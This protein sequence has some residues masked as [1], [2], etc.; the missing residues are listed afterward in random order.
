M[1]ILTLVFA[2]L[3]IF[4]PIVL[5]LRFSR[6]STDQIALVVYCYIFGATANIIAA[7]SVLNFTAELLILIS[8]VCFFLSCF[9]ISSQN[10]LAVIGK[11]FLYGGPALTFAVSFVEKKMEYVEVIRILSYISLFFVFVF[12]PSN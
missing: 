6:N 1:E 10:K 3:S 7:S 4:F 9:F 2:S 8:S 12:D 11:L 5:K